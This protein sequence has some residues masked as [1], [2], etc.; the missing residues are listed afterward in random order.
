MEGEAKKILSNCQTYL[1][2][3]ANTITVMKH[4]VQTI[5][6]KDDLMEL[7]KSI[8]ATRHNIANKAQSIK[9]EIKEL[10]EKTYRVIDDSVS[11]VRKIKVMTGLMLGVLNRENNPRSLEYAVQVFEKKTVEIQPMIDDVIGKLDVAKQVLCIV[12]KLRSLKTII[13]NEQKSIRFRQ[14]LAVIDE[15]LK[16]LV[17]A[18]LVVGGRFYYKFVKDGV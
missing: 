6:L 3:Y 16:T 15:K 4:A 7:A 10:D 17:K 18:A 1:N 9:E 5:L 2:F 14:K 12:E 13:E 8:V 11:L